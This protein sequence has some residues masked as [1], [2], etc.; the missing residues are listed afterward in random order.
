MSGEKRMFPV[1]Q[2]STAGSFTRRNSLLRFSI[3]SFFGLRELF[4]REYNFEEVQS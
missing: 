1:D 4:E 3:A 2:N